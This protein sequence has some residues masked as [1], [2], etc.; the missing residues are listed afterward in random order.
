V[1]NL[2]L[3]VA[4]LVIGVLARKSG[5]LPE[6]TPVAATRAVIFVALPALTLVT[7]QRLRLGSDAWRELG[8]ALGTPLVIFCVAAAVI[9]M[10]R[11]AL[12]ASRQ[13]SG[14]LLLTAGLANTSFVGFPLVEALF[15]REG[16]ERAILV[17]QG[18]FLVLA[19]LGILVASAGKGEAR[20]SLHELGA[21]LLR[22]P[23]F[24]AFALAIAL[25]P[26]ALPAHATFVLEKL[27]A[28]VVPLALFAVGWQLRLEAA[29]LAEHARPLVLGLAVRLLL[30]PL[31]VYLLVQQ[32][33]GVTG[34]AGDV[35]VAEA[36]MAP[37]ITGA[38]LATQ[39]DLAPRLA[40]LMVG[41]GVPLSLVTVPVWAWLVR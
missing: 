38:L 6:A 28:L 4:Y 3:V 27:G 29:A 40:T 12:G 34:L 33:L 20:P 2:L 39:A 11:R 32:A 8:V 5:R 26:V 9:A 13:V 16:L 7:I 23:P 15:G 19:T 17:D 36:A 37:M 41:V 24:L 22:F 10:S 18:Q 21:R 14:C 25:R 31:A 35:A 1:T 30:A